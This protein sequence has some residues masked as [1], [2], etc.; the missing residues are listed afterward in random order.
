MRGLFGRISARFDAFLAGRRE[1]QH[2][3]EAKNPPP[4]EP[5]PPPT[6]PPP[7]AWSHWPM[8][9]IEKGADEITKAANP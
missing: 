2:I 9:R 1:H 4:Q 5:P 7:R 6:P 3:Q 8:K